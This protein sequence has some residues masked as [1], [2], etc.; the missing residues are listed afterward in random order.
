MPFCITEVQE[1][2]TLFSDRN[3]F[4]QM[5]V[6]KPRGPGKR[7]APV[8]RNR[9]ARGK[10]D[11]EELLRNL[12]LLEAKGTL[13][14]NEDE[15]MGDVDMSLHDSEDVP[16][17]VEKPVSFELPHPRFNAQLAVQNDMLYI[18]GGTFE[19]GDREFTFDEMF[20]IDL[21]KLDGVREIFRREVEDWQGSDDEES[22]DDEDG[23]EDDDD[24]SVDEDPSDHVE[25]QQQVSSKPDEPATDAVDAQ[26]STLAADDIEVEDDEE[27]A[28][29][30]PVPR[31]F[32]S[33]RQFFVRTL[34]QWQDIVFEELKYKQGPANKTS[35]E[36]RGTAFDKAEAKWWDCREEIQAIED[37][38]EEAGIGEVVDLA[39][40][41]TAET[42]SGR[43]R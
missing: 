19:R 18:Y 7:S 8:E 14:A 1:S 33:L 29:G 25:S 22:E 24:M 9:R 40:R 15:M 21:G 16:A 23:D 17:A 12:A 32:E 34:Q 35:K 4:F 20:A 30:R 42:G 10:A 37:E 27:P 2:L 38:H 28:D 3:R 5:A 31:P 39:D 11:E 41:S 36:L 6:R 13:A 26:A 43:R